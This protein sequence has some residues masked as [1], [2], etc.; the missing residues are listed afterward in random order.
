MCLGVPAQIIAIT[1]SRN[2]LARVDV[3]G[4]QREVNITCIVTHDQIPE[5]CVGQWVLIHAGFAMAHIDENEARKTLALLAE[6]E[7][8]TPSGL[9][10][11]G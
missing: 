10:G 9:E 7:A 4:V 2:H 6:L 11:D 8:S 1:D 5:T 3:A